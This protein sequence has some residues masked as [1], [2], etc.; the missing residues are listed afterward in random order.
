M[1][2]END[3]NPILLYHAGYDNLIPMDVERR[4]V[5]HFSCYARCP[6]HSLTPIRA[7]CCPK[8]FGLD[9]DRILVL[10]KL[11]RTRACG[12]IPGIHQDILVGAVY[13][14]QRTHD[15]PGIDANPSDTFVEPMQHNPNSHRSV[16]P[17]AQAEC[18]GRLMLVSRK[19]LLV[20]SPSI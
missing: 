8:K 2:V 10:A 14:Q 12:T 15:L 4:E 17:I 3:I 11:T 18:S 7:E 19:S 1:R 5:T 13:L 6:R 16:L 9:L 20:I